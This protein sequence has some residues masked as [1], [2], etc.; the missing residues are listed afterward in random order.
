MLPGGVGIYEALMTAVLVATGVPAAVSIPVTV[1]YRVLS[2]LVQLPPGYYYYHKT[3]HSNGNIDE[4][5]KL[6]A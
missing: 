2:M 6:H 4:Q 3:I 1:M 5:A